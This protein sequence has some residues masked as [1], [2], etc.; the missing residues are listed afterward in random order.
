[1]REYL[2]ENGWIENADP[3]SH[4]FDLKYTVKKAEIDYVNLLDN[5]IIN[6]YQNNKAL[7]SKYGLCLNLR[8]R[9]AEEVD[10]DSFFPRCFDITN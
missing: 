2:L 10:I 3:D 6:H 1:L 8:N 9:I 5:Q 4:Y 7:T